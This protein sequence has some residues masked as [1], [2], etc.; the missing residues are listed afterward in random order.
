MANL[1]KVLEKLAE[2]GYVRIDI[3]L[4]GAICKDPREAYLAAKSLRS[5]G[6]L[7]PEQYNARGKPVVYTIDWDLAKR[8]YGDELKIPEEFYKQY[9]E[10]K[11]REAERQ[12]QEAMEYMKS[13]K[14]VKEGEDQDEQ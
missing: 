12:K 3:G 10:W 7:R 2:L 4:L 6:I 11:K 5:A 13:M 9:Q 1:V 8:F 14:P